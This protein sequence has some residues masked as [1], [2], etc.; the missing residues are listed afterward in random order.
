MRMIW[1]AVVT[2][3]ERERFLLQTEH[4][5]D[6]VSAMGTEEDIE[7][8]DIKVTLSG[9]LHGGLKVMH[10]RVHQVSQVLDHP[11]QQVG[12]ENFVFDNKNSGRNVA[13]PSFTPARINGFSSRYLRLRAVT[14]DFKALRVVALTFYIQP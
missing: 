4:V 10:G 7:K 5:S 13:P 1:K 3:D 12:D 8:G 2:G 9:V 11:L 6:V 14:E